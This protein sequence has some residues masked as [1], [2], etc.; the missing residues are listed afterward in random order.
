MRRKSACAFSMTAFASRTSAQAFWRSCG[1]EPF[2]SSASRS[3]LTASVAWASAIRPRV[4]SSCRAISVFSCGSR[5][6]VACS[7]ARSRSTSASSS[8]LSRRPTRSPDAS[9][10][11]SSTGRSMTRP[12]ILKLTATSVASIVPEANRMPSGSRVHQRQAC[13]PPMT[14][15]ATR[16]RITSRFRFV[17]TMC[18]ISCSLLL[19]QR[20][21]QVQGDL[22]VKIHSLT[23]GEMRCPF[24]ERSCRRP[25]QAG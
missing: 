9:R 17:I 1:R 12:G 4:S 18:F 13:V 25:C 20:R 8:R 3:S 16:G 5:V 24:V 19:P 6:S 23:G 15:N 14:S 11:P 10:S 2:F 7:E 21:W 22:E